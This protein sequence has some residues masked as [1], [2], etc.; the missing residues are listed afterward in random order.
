MPYKY[1]N[2]ERLEKQKGL[3]EGLLEGIKL[4]LCLK[5]GDDSLEILSEISHISDI[6]VLKA[7]LVGIKQAN[8]I[9]NLRSIYQ[10]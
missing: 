3:N 9:E 2:K 4:G 10:D 6:E 5:F 1:T 7:I 8:S